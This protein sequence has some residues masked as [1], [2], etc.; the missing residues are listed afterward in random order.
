MHGDDLSKDL[1]EAVSKI[2]EK[3]TK[4]QEEIN[5]FV[6]AELEKLGVQSPAELPASKRKDLFNKVDKR[7]TSDGEADG[8]DVEPDDK[9][10]KKNEACDKDKIH[11]GRAGILIVFSGK[12]PVQGSPG[13]I[14]I[15]KELMK[16]IT[17]KKIIKDNRLLFVGQDGKKISP[18]DF[19][20]STTAR[21]GTGTWIF[22]NGKPWYSVSA[23]S[24]QSD[25]FVLDIAGRGDSGPPVQMARNFINSLAEQML[26][27]ELMNE[28]SDLA[29][30][31]DAAEER[32]FRVEI[33][34][35]ATGKGVVFMV[36]AT[37]HRDAEQKALF[38]ARDEK[39]LRN[40]PNIGG[41]Q[42]V[43]DSSTEISQAEF[44]AGEVAPPLGPK[45]GRNIPNE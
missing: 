38:A 14:V 44:D 42:L 27:D 15:K 8:T 18:N 23:R 36:D 41:F 31:L 1:I 45:T 6:K 4:E 29:T 21:R 9:E 37:S 11:E 2:T 34:N 25:Q 33:L 24:G 43:A 22:S 30:G 10:A 40:P 32:F 39:D 7:F 17:S 12:S 3:K 20:K 13:R 35:G 26:D 16:F 28:A 5:K 19:I